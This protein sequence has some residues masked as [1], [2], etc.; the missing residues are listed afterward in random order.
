VKLKFGVQCVISTTR[1]K[2]AILF[3]Q[4]INSCPLIH[5]SDYTRICVSAQQENATA[6]SIKPFQ[7]DQS[8]TQFHSDRVS[9]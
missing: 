6:H 9:S 4:I 1:V 3:Y 8:G 7:H 5:L 2:G